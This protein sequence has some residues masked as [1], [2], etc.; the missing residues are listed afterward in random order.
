MGL[1]PGA[2]SS[3]NQDYEETDDVLARQVNTH[4]VNLGKSHPQDF[5]TDKIPPSDEMERA[6]STQAMPAKL[7][8]EV[9]LV[10]VGDYTT[11]DAMYSP[12]PYWTQEHCRSVRYLKDI[13][14]RLRYAEHG[15]LTGW[16]PSNCY[17]FRPESAEVFR[18][19]LAIV[20]PLI[21]PTFERATSG[22]VRANFV[23]IWS[24]HDS[25]PEVG[26]PAIQNWT[27]PG[28]VIGAGNK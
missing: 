21:A 15:L 8:G 20:K 12:A 2:F 11:I 14:A 24:F 7:F 28:P 18:Q 23:G 4:I 25:C 10:F 17:A 16:H 13:L 26:L 22:V 9:F 27:D 6:W 5:G 19:Y 3:H 1:N